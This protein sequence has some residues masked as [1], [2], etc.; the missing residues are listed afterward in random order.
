MGLEAF[1]ILAILLKKFFENYF[2]RIMA[3]YSLKLH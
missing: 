3:N 1:E 2:E